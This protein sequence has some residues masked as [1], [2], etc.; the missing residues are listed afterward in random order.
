MTDQQDSPKPLDSETVAAYL[1]LHPEFFIDHDELIPELRIPHQRGD[2][3]SLVERQVK[4]L[5]ERNIEMR[6]RLSQLMDVAR[7]NDRLFEKTRRLTLD[8]LD[9]A[10]LE[11]VVIAVED[12]LRNEF[13]V[14]FVSLILFSETTLPVGRSM[15]ISE[16]QQA[17]GGLM[18][19]GK[20]ISGALREHELAFLFGKT[21]ATDVGSAA[22]ATISHQG[23]HGVLAIGSADPQ[24]YKSS[25]GTLFL[26][27]IAEVLARVLPRLA[28]PLRS[29]R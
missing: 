4:L 18:T 27:Y 2:T 9:A 16:A 21:A 22:V 10:S 25:V 14:P 19:S 7:D 20:T 5:R 29:V 12:S 28:T 24:H 17:I 3:I 13:Q 1:R 6:H 23:Q 11:E 26:S 8:I 15:A